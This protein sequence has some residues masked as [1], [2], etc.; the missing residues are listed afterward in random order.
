MATNAYIGTIVRDP[1]LRYS[2]KTGK[3]YTTNA[4][5]V[6]ERFRDPETGRWEEGETQFFNI[7]AFGSNAEHLCASLQKRDRVIVVGEEKDGRPYVKNGEE[8]TPR[9]IVV[10]E[11]GASLRFVDVRIE[12][13]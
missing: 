6:S 5:K 2:D 12:G 4:I 8:I 13:D 7:V 1:E 9:E 10:E 11:I 3:A